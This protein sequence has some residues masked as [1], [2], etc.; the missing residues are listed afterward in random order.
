MTS[1]GNI[2][3]RIPGNYV[4]PFFLL[5]CH[6]FFLGQLILRPPICSPSAGGLKTLPRCRTQTVVRI[7]F[8]PK[9]PSESDVVLRYPRP[10]PSPG[11]KGA[12]PNSLRMEGGSPEPPPSR[13][14]KPLGPKS[15]PYGRRPAVSSSCSPCAPSPPHGNPLDPK[16]DSFATIY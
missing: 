5:W 2:F 6:Y 16:P 7:S 1:I 14:G 4:T 12:F 15:P 3:N 8:K 9:D 13:E 11:L 10:P